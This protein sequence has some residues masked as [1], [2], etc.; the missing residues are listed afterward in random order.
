[1]KQNGRAD[2]VD[3]CDD[4]PYQTFSEVEERFEIVWRQEEN[5]DWQALALQCASLVLV[6]LR[7]PQKEET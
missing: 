7:T 5:P 4:A 1:M 3:A 6:A 2:G